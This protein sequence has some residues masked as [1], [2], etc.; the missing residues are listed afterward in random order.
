MRDAAVHTE[1]DRLQRTQLPGV[2]PMVKWIMIANAVVFLAQNLLGTEFQQGLLEFGALSV[3]RVVQGYLWQPAT[4]MWLHGSLMHVVFNMFALWMFGGVLESVWGSRRFLRFYLQCG[5]GAGMI[6]FLWNAMLGFPYPTL[7]A[8]GAIFGLLTAFSLMWPE[9]T[10]F[11][12]PFPVPIKA[13]WFIPILFVLQFMWGGEQISYVGHL[14]GVLIA[15]F[16]MRNELLRALKLR[17]LRYYW[18][19]MRMRRK[20]RT[21]RKDE[22]ERKR[23]SRDDDD[24]PTFH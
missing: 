9:R 8:S 5:I 4:Y 17:N 1:G 14:G 16:L 23:R 22:F 10:V 24:R 18:H 6:I 20:L 3:N 15:G 21:V 19:R 13:I 11:I 7:G 12:F 2:T